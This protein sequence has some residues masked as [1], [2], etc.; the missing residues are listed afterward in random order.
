MLISVVIPV[1][2]EEQVIPE[3]LSRISTALAA[4]REYELILVDDGSQ[5]KTSELLKEAAG[6]DRRIKVIKLARNFGHQIAL[7]AGLAHAAGDV[8]MIMDGDLQDP[9]E[10]I[11]QFIDKWREG[12]QVVY[13]I[14]KTR[15]ENILKRAAYKIFYRILHSLASINIPLDAGD[16]CLM[17]R[18]VVIEL[19]KLPEHNRFLR[20]LRAWMGSKSIGLEIDRHK[21]F[22]GQTKYSWRKLF[23]LAF[24]GIVGFSVTPLRL[25]SYLGFFIAG[26]SF[27]AGL[28]LFIMKFTVGISL[29]GWTSIIVVV[30]FLSG[31]QL[32]TLGIIGEYLGRIFIEV[33]NRSL[34]IIDETYGFE[35]KS[36]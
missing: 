20:G 28:I 3:L 15:Q 25:S 16:C 18:K 29:Q 7:S 13:G 31:I 12:Y 27:V 5:D 23:H 22:A 6:R 21:R 8:V 11:D 10:L 34:Y 26:I 2:N 14:R 19:N 4:G 1:F 35:K 30:F 36:D 17:D 9:P 32:L 33:Q 24:D